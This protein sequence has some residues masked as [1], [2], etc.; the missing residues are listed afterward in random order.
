MHHE[1]YKSDLQNSEIQTDLLYKFHL[2]MLLFHQLADGKHSLPLT[3]WTDTH[4]RTQTYQCTGDTITS[5]IL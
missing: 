2:Y 5:F 4:H 3:D 1:L